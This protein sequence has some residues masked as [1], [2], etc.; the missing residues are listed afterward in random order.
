MYITD[1]Y[2]RVKCSKCG[3]EIQAIL[4]GQEFTLQECKNC[5][6]QKPKTRSKKVVKDGKD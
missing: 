1:A 6:P 4:P 5:K 2:A 3:E